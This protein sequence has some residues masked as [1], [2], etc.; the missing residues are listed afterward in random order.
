[1]VLR[2]LP[3]IA[4]LGALLSG[5]Y[6]QAM[7]I[8]KKLDKQLFEAVSGSKDLEG[9]VA[10]LLVEGANPNYKKFDP[11]LDKTIDFTNQKDTPLHIA[12]RSGHLNSAFLLLEEKAW[13]NAQN[14]DGLTALHEAIW[15]TDSKAK[16]AIKLLYE[17]GSDL[18]PQDKHGN[19][20]F[21]LA[22]KYKKFNIAD[23][24]LILGTNINAQNKLGN[25]ALH[26]TILDGNKEGVRYLLRKNALT[27]IKNNK[28]QTPFLLATEMNEFYFVFLLKAREP[29]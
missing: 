7:D 24:F 1:M 10:T 20:P 13:V 23:I 18:D 27:T 25:T 8:K 14:T 16:E 29:E 6:L 9:K 19:T 26:Q 5:S 4:L 3:I 2:K 22:I 21:H 12:I 11:P 28:K 17:Y 15:L